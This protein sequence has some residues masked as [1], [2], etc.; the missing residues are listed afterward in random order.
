MWMYCEFLLISV[1]EKSTQFD[2]DSSEEGGQLLTQ[3]PWYKYPVL[4]AVQ[5]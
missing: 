2:P 1:V 5:A 4:Q 3:V